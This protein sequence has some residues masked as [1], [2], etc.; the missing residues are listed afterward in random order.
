MHNVIIGG[1]PAG[2]QAALA[3]RE[4]EQEVTLVNAE[5]EPF[6]SRVLISHYLGGIKPRENV[7]LYGKDCYEQL[8]IKAY[9][10]RQA[11]KVDVGAKQ[12]ILD[13]DE[14]LP[15]DNLL[16]ASGGEPQ[17]PPIPGRELPGVFSLYTLADAD[18]IKEWVRPGKPAVVIGG[19]LVGIKALEGLME[20]NLPVSLVEIMDHIMPQVVDAGAAALLQEALQE[21]G[22]KLYLNNSVEAIEGKDQVEAVRL[23]DGTVIPCH[24]VIFGTGVK[25]AVKFLEGTGVKINNGVVVDEYLQ[26]SV[27]GIYAAGD[28]AEAADTIYGEKRVNALW[29]VATHQ[30][31]IA[32]I[33]MAGGKESFKGHASVNTVELLGLRVVSFGY[34]R[35][36]AD[37]QEAVVNLPAKKAYR[38]LIYQGNILKGGVFV[39]SVQGSGILYWLARCGFAVDCVEELLANPAERFAYIRDLN[40]KMVANG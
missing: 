16:L 22:V 11:V 8:G 6:Y 31:R 1:G 38:K 5:N 7:Y 15:Y 13:N 9:L 19:G 12:V 3:L 2:Y 36:E 17:V 27:P 4:A 14:S 25:P 26:S 23:K 29:P 34:I 39:N 37:F 18:A 24:L 30:G 40:Q 20:M 21:K 33:N 32:G 35:P 10:G 28:V